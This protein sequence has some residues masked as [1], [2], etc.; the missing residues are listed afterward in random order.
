VRNK[1]L[2]HLGSLWSKFVVGMFATTMFFLF[3]SLGIFAENASSSSQWFSGSFFFLALGCIAFSA[4]SFH[5]IRQ[6]YL[7]RLE[8]RIE[9][10]H[11]RQ[12]IDFLGNRKQFMKSLIL[13]GVVIYFGG[14]LGAILTFPPLHLN[15]SLWPPIIFVVITYIGATTLLLGANSYMY[16]SEKHLRQ[17]IE[18]FTLPDED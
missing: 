12:R 13:L 18:G 11:H 7:N 9:E 1:I 5:N 4:H 3:G 15:E 2:H 16:W 14:T 17:A 8:Q 10:M 6:F